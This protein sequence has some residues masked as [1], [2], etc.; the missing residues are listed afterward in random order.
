MRSDVALVVQ[1]DGGALPAPHGLAAP[2]ALVVLAQ[3]GDDGEPGR[4][5]AATGL[6]LGEAVGTW[7]R[8]AG[9]AGAAVVGYRR[10]GAFGALV[11]RGGAAA[12]RRG[13]V[14]PRG[15]GC[16]GSARCRRGARCGAV[17]RGL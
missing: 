13:H 16:G 15:A 4:L 7:R 17:R 6:A 5:D 8:G 14:G 10:R 12:V 3:P 11:R 1:R 9:G 2:D